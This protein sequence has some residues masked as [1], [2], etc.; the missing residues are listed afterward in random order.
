MALVSVD[1]SATM[2]V[3]SARLVNQTCRPWAKLR[4]S[5]RWTQNMAVS[6][7]DVSISVDVGDSL[8]SLKR[9]IVFAVAAS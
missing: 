2:A 4:K 3:F 7:R 8:G 9:R 5:T 1:V 6:Q